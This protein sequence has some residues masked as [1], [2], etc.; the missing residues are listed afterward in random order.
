MSEE[1]ILEEA[2]GRFAANTAAV[3]LVRDGVIIAQGNGRG[4]SPLLDLGDQSPD[5]VKGAWVIDKVIGKAA[6]AICVSAGA[7]RVH[8]ALMCE[9]AQALLEEHGIA[10]SADKVVPQILN[11]DQSGL[12]PLEASVAELSSV[13]AML[14]AIRAKLK[15]LRKAAAEA[16]L[17]EKKAN[18]K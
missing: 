3:V 16:N 4:L 10:F 13:P 11:R 12:C 6:A 9:P 7:R 2:R 5:A 8:G 15:Q 17:K 1:E 18:A 14:T